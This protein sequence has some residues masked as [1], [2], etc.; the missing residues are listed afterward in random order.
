MTRATT[1]SIGT[2]LTLASALAA[3]HPGRRHVLGHGETAAAIDAAPAVAVAPD[4]QEAPPP[5]A[6]AA[7]PATLTF[8]PSPWPAGQTIRMWRRVRLADVPGSDPIT[9]EYEVVLAVTASDD[10]ATVAIGD[11]CNAVI[12]RGA[13]RVTGDC[14]GNAA[15]VGYKL[16]TAAQLLAVPQGT[17]TVG[18]VAP[19]FARPIVSLFRLQDAGALVTARLARV[20]ASGA[21]Y[22]VHV[23]LDGLLLRSGLHL[24]GV[25]DGELTVDA[26][27]RTMA[28]TLRAPR[29]TIDGYPQAGYPS[30]GSFEMAFTIGPR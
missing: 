24:T 30:P 16:D 5:P 6:D 23:E 22:A 10:S 19:G 13:A 28:A 3:C 26:Q 7:P 4:A 12:G 1:W 14:A 20:D 8:A 25:A 17:A 2:T 11:D 21:V 29:V 18:D 15:D 9:S 27:A